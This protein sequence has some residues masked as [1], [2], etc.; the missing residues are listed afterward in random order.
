MTGHG[1]PDRTWVD[2]IL[3]DNRYLVIGTADEAGTPWAVPLFF[4]ALD[5]DTVVWVSAADSRH[6]T[7]IEKRPEVALTVPG[8]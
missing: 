4:A 7:N 3:T 6:S 2:R 1:K 5:P 8:P